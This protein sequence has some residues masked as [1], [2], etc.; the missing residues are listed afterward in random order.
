MGGWL[1]LVQIGLYATILLL[2]VQFFND[3]LPALQSEEWDL[4]TTK[5]SELY[6]PM[7]QPVLI[8]EI[9]ANVLLLLMSFYCLYNLYRRKSILPKL[10]II[11]YSGS[12]AAGIIDYALLNQIALV[13]EFD[14]LDADIMRDNVRAAITCAIW[15]PYF[16][17][18][19]RVQNTFIR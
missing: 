2:I 11:F 14:L 19:E 9:A 6:D 5:G 12:L 4:L 7:W 1:V 8:F 3:T 15:I 18:S 13:K 16:I 10:M 17:K